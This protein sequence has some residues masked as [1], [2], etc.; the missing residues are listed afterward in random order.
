MPPAAVPCPGQRRAEGTTS[1]SLVLS[2]LALPI[3]KQGDSLG[4]WVPAGGEGETSLS[5][6]PV[7]C[8]RW[9]TPM[10]PAP[11]VMSP[12]VTPSPPLGPPQV[13]ISPGAR[14]RSG[15]R[16]TPLGS[17]SLMGAPMWGRTPSP[18]PRPCGDTLPEPAT[19][20][21][22]A[23]G[24]ALL[25]STLSVCLSSCPLPGV[26]PGPGAQRDTRTPRGEAEPHG[27][28]PQTA[29]GAD[30]Q[31][32]P[33]P[34]TAQ[35]PFTGTVPPARGCRDPRQPPLPPY[36]TALGGWGQGEWGRHAAFP[37]HSCERPPWKT[38]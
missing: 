8:T 12:T 7:P 2:Q 38:N 21:P 11:S 37:F 4:T 35:P 27:W 22:P 13:S 20:H 29:G 34:K 30:T 25:S 6:L 23:P 14:G 19:I 26:T 32:P 24:Q 15:D 10:N 36:P 5:V 18:W 31:T 16:D 28:G 17:G 1:P 3:A 33:G 9:Q